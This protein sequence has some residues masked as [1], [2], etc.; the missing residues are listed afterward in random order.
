MANKTTNSLR[1]LAKLLQ[2]VEQQQAAVKLQKTAAVITALVG[3]E[4]LKRKV[5][6]H[7]E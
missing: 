6:G 2:Q 3:L 7:A 4:F 5:L 1:K